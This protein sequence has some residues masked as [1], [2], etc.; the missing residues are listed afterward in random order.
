MASRVVII[1]AVATYTQGVN[2]S[3]ANVSVMQ[4]DITNAFNSVGWSV[5]SCVVVPTNADN[6]VYGIVMSFNVETQYSIAQIQTSFKSTLTANGYWITPDI[7]DTR[8]MSV[9]GQAAPTVTQ[10]PILNSSLNALQVAA[11]KSI[12]PSNAGTFSKLATDIGVSVGALGL[13]AAAIVLVISSRK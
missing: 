1:Q 3:G 10:N 13:F 2:G 5:N 6:P 4:R 8:E 9:I 7:T 12:P 11:V